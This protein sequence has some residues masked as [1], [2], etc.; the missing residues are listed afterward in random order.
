M[1]PGG[2]FAG[3]QYG[4]AVWSN[5]PVGDV[6]RSGL[7]RESSSSHKWHVGKCE[8]CKADGNEAIPV[9]PM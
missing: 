3:E 2:G 8:Q 7:T 9:P 1:G 6:P 4:K 5:Y